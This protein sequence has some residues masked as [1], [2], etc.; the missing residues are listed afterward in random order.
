[1]CIKGDDEEEE[2]KW[3]LLR[4]DTIF[5]GFG[6]KLGIG[7]PTPK[8]ERGGC[9]RRLGDAA[10]LYFL[11]DDRFGIGPSFVGAERNINQSHF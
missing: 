9:D 2:Q 10:E 11:R 8:M 4:A 3:Q 5:S 1:M 6:W 7:E